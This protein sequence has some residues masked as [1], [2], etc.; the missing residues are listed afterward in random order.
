MVTRQLTNHNGK[1]HIRDQCLHYFYSKDILK[2]HKVDYTQLNKCKIKLPIPQDNILSFKNYNRQ[3]K[4]LYIIYANFECLL[5][6]IED[7]EAS[8]AFQEHEAY[9]IGY[10]LKCSFHDSR[11][12]YHSYRQKEVGEMSPAV[13]FIVNLQELATHLEEMYNAPKPMNLTHRKM[14]DF[15]AAKLCHF[16][17]KQFFAKDK[18]IR[19]HCHITGK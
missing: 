14:D 11:S 10:Y 8:R 9:S 2:K 13:W 1:C 4:V 18:K 15:E 6:P 5:K 19:D 12:G 16:C 7:D 3:T 17:I